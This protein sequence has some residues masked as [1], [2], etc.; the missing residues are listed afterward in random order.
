[1]RRHPPDLRRPL[2]HPPATARPAAAPV[3]P[4]HPPARPPRPPPPPAPPPPP[5]ALR[6]RR[7]AAPLARPRPLAP[8]RAR[9]VQRRPPLSPLSKYAG[10]E[11]EGRGGS[12]P[13]EAAA[14]GGRARVPEGPRARPRPL[15]RGGRVQ[16][17]AYCCSCRAVQP[18]L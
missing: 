2:H 12:A 10:G 13:F 3:P 18:R 16:R 11:A 8:T 9:H 15:L 6:P 1:A 17:R 7:P 5:P 4:A 14:R